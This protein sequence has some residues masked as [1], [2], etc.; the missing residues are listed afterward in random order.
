[1]KTAHKSNVKNKQEADMTLPYY[2]DKYPHVSRSVTQIAN[3]IQSLPTLS[4]AEKMPN[5]QFEIEARMGTINP[6]TGEFVAGV[7]RQFLQQTIRLLDQF[8]DWQKVMPWQEIVDYF[9]PIPKKQDTTGRTSVFMDPETRELKT[10]H[11]K[12]HNEKKVTLQ[13][14][15]DVVKLYDV[16][17]ALNFEEVLTSSVLPTHTMPS[18]VRIKNRKR[19]MYAHDRNDEPVWS[20][21]VTRCWSGKT[22][23]EAEKNQ[24]EDRTTY[25]VEV[26]CLNPIRYQQKKKQDEMYTATSLLLK[27]ARLFDVE[28]HQFC[29]LPYN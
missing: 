9:Y 18:L 8:E 21:D 17:V 16:R 24:Q 14:T 19:Y 12:K 28:D 29:L 22:R 15:S 27:V 6:S 3:L 23:A 7:T 20:F 2:L 5:G 1:M 10:M 13:T 4:Q 25:E 26:E 11:M